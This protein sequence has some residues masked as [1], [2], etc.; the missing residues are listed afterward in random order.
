MLL[1]LEVVGTQAGRLGEQRSKLFAAEGGSIGRVGGNDW[2]LPDQFVSSRHAAIQYADGQFY[3]IDTNSSN[4]VFLNSPNFRLEQGRP[5]PIKTGDR[6]LIDPF[7]IHV[8][9]VEAAPQ[10]LSLLDAPETQSVDRPLPSPPLTPVRPPALESDPFAVEDEVPFIGTVPAPASRGSL[11]DQS[12]IPRSSD[13]AEEPV[14]PLVALGLPGGPKAAPPPRVEDLGRGSPLRSSFEAPRIIPSRS[15]PSEDIPARGPSVTPMPAI[16]EDYNPL[17]TNIEQAPS[18]P[19]PPPAAPR[20]P[21]PPP[22]RPEYRQAAADP[23][24]PPR[25]AQPPKAA[26]RPAPV[27]PQRAPPS[28]AVSPSKPKAPPAPVA[29]V[30]PAPARPPA[31]QPPPAPARVAAPPPPAPS[32]PP[33][34]PAAAAPA[35]GQLDFAALLAAAGLEGVQVTP[36]LASS[37]GS[38]L[39]TVVDG[40]RDVLRA[41]EELKD[42]FRLRI[43]NYAPRENNPIKFAANTEDALHNLLV[44]RNSAYLEP[45]AAFEGAF[46]DLRIHMMAMLAGMRAGYEAMLGNFDPDTLEQKFER[47]AKRG[48]LLGG[49]TKQRYWE[50]YRDVFKD[51]AGDA[52]DSFRT[53]FGT[54]FAQGYDEQVRL[55]KRRPHGQ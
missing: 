55:L 31:P 39:K 45:V 13:R 2:V 41:R 46:D 38:I 49:A 7:E 42:Q 11:R 33:A 44:R 17:D 26:Q 29:A 53:L 47:H 27:A 23:P 5:Y 8:S 51:M 37:F 9:V 34:A 25:E 12:L 50:L 52:D 48:G 22:A 30:R 18:K 15:P 36:E 6:L 54:A 20:R 35:T 14:D 32:R 10:D 40:L 3:V 16:P 24:P 1:K 4:G 19:A 28:P 21:P 43:T